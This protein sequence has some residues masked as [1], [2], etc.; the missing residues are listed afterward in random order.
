MGTVRGYK[1][2]TKDGRIIFIPTTHY[3]PKIEKNKLKSLE[4]LEKE[5]KSQNTL[6]KEESVKG[7]YGYYT[8]PAESVFQDESG[9]ARSYGS[10]NRLGNQGQTRN[11]IYLPKNTEAYK[12]WSKDDENWLTDEQKLKIATQNEMK[13]NKVFGTKSDGYVSL[14]KKGDLHR[15][16]RNQAV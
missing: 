16:Y 1:K 10:S 2:R 13:N 3:T 6:P 11:P 7:M 9:E 8:K 14:M 5:Y 15:K 12:K 4:Q